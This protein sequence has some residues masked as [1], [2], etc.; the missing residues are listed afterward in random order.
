M[1]R[2]T[3]VCLGLLLLTGA[4]SLEAQHRER[5]RTSRDGRVVVCERDRDH[6][7]ERPRHRR[8]RSIFRDRG[9]VEFG[10]R[11]GYDFEDHQGSAG[12][13]IRIPVV[14][15]FAMSPSFD[16]FF[17]DEGASWQ[18]NL[19]GLIRPVRL[20]GLY[21]GGGVALLRADL[22]GTGVETTAG[23][24]LLAGME[25]GRITSTALRP[26]VEA[27]WTGVDDF[28]GFRLVAG[29]NVPITGGG[30]W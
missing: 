9:P 8:S 21:A 7:R 27:R 18:L 22:D 13:Q 25:G 10:I 26:F 16:A 3:L 1:M 15:Q 24:N 4:G 23:W 29:V 11:G 5:C 30:R 19:D 2:R 6:D 14:R 28:Q 20:G 17:G 12:T